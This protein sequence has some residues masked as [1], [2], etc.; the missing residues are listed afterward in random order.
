V[1]N[2]SDFGIGP[3]AAISDRDEQILTQ[4]RLAQITIHPD[5]HALILAVANETAAGQSNEDHEDRVLEILNIRHGL[6][7]AEWRLPVLTVMVQWRYHEAY[8]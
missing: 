8:G 3:I 2:D 5:A 6:H 4:A 7:E 1:G